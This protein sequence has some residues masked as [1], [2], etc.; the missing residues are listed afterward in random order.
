[1]ATTAGSKETALLLDLRFMG[2]LGGYIITLSA[3]VAS[4]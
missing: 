4:T 2:L 1:M 3:H